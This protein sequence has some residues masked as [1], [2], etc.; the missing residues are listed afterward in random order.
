MAFVRNATQVFSF[1][2]YQDVVDQDQRLFLENEGLTQ[3]LVEQGLVRATE[4]LINRFSATSWWRDYY[5]RRDTTTY[6]R[7]PSDI[8]PMNALRIV[9][10]FQTFTDLCVYTAL[11]AYILP[12]VADFSNEDNA[13]RQK[14]DYYQQQADIL[15]KELV[16][17]SDWYDF[18]GSGTVSSEEREPGRYNPRRI[19]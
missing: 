8:P 2:E 17:A 15:F 11:S 1:A 10:R 12:A 3:D 19:R 7:T 18:D 9:G 5:Q 6:F 16:E 13:E 4:R 14:M